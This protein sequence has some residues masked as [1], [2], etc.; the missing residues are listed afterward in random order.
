MTE[1]VP[2]RR[3]RLAA[4]V[5]VLGLAAAMTV[6][7]RIDSLAARAPAAATGG[8]EPALLTKPPVRV[9]G[10]SKI[11][12]GGPVSA[13]RGSVA[14]PAGSNAGMNL[15]RAHTTYWFSP[16]VHTLGRG[17]YD[18][19]IAG[20]GARYVGAPGAVL[21]GQR[22]NTAFG[23]T[24]RRVTVEYL[25]IE[26]F[27]TPGNQGAVNASAA[28]DWTIKYDTIRDVVPGT[29]L[30]AGTD[31][32]IE[33][34]CLTRNGQSGFGT[35]T[36]AD[37]SQ[38]THGAS[39]V[40]IDHNEIS[41]NDTCN[42]EGLTLWPGPAP[43]P[44][45]RGV[46]ASP[47]CGCSGGGK[48]WQTDGGAFDDNFVH[49]NY[50]TGVWWDSDNTG[51]D[52]ERN[53][54]SGNYGNGLIYEI[55]YNAVIRGNTFVRNGLVSGPLNPGFPTAAVY[56]SESGSD[57][58]VPGSYRHVFLI[59]QNAFRDNWSGVVLWENSN[60]FCNSP[61]NTSGGDCTLV[62]A[63]VSRVS[64]CNAASIAH[65]PYYTDC[66]WLTRNVLV[67]HNIFEFDPPHL[68]PA[69]TA[70]SRCG[71]QG[72]FSE[73]GT[74]PA[75]SPYHATVVEDHLTFAQGNHF[76]ANTYIGPWRFIV[77]DQGNVVDRMV[78]QAKPYGQ[79]AGSTFRGGV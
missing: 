62:G 75:W 56:I 25:T 27:T 7:M 6:V 67:D 28:A 78:W 52:I 12:R 57:A 22:I 34:N 26:N 60:R 9:C 55:S 59:T 40:V 31:N 53:Y 47:G 18:Q 5:L 3:L 39:N 13:P 20:A 51:F 1:L 37:T 77:H 8:R 14:V 63:P 23:G 71:F 38:L 68:G 21:D 54:V 36:V 35:Y 19:I 32:V 4:G 29:A 42:W 46:T 79:D 61:A 44:G 64:S 73:Y 43:P 11:L 41:Q 69:C 24:A 66:R 15:G 58:R 76:A 30:Y 33:Y 50:G 72:L 45:C 49:D 48:F 10:N 65:V 17:V 16:G 74:Y 2:S 70:A